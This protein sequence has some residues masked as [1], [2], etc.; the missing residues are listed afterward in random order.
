[1]DCVSMRRL[2]GVLGWLG[3]TAFVGCSGGG[4]VSGV[5]PVSGKVT[6]QG[7]PVGGATIVFLSE[8]ADGRPA[9]ATSN[10]DGTYEL[11]TL[12]SKGALPGKYSVTVK[13][14]ENSQDLTRE[15]SMEEAAANANAPPPVSKELLP[16]KYGDPGQTPL[17]FEVKSGSNKI[18]LELTD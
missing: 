16:A 4:S 17:K 18:D 10:P 11:L 3:L 13:K 6:Y 12:E 8:A 9:V 7:Q 2:V 1:M 14:T 5:A 15:V